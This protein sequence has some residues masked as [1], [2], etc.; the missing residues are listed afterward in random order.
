M[1]G[2]KYPAEAMGFVFFFRRKKEEEE[3]TNR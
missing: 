3:E 1:A 2:T